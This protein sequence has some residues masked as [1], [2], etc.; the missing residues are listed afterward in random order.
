MVERRGASPEGF[1]PSAP[2]P[3]PNGMRWSNG[4]GWVAASANVAQG[5]YVGPFA[6]VLGGT[7][8]ATARIEEHATV[9]A[10]TVSGG[11]IGGLPGSGSGA[12]V[13]GPGRV[14]AACARGPSWV[15]D[16]RDGPRSRRP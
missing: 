1:Q 9:I 4:G 3:S 7:V 10:G 8:G 16:A 5:A 15:G 12:Q 2:N 14:A 11:T 13:G 6:A